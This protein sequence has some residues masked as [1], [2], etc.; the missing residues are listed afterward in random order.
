[1]GYR[2]HFIYSAHLDNGAPGYNQILLPV[3]RQMILPRSCRQ[4]H[5]VSPEVKF[6]YLNNSVTINHFCGLENI[7]FINNMFNN[8]CGDIQDFLNFM[9]PYV[10]A[11]FIG[12][13]EFL[14][15]FGD[16][17]D[18]EENSIVHLI[19]KGTVWGRGGLDE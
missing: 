19:K 8:I 12:S 5:F 18:G 4:N 17:K 11:P 2:N 16:H 10:F 15:F 9:D 1:M 7:I 6:D 13:S 3:I 14:G